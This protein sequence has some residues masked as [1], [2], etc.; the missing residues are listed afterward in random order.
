MASI[1]PQDFF[2]KKRDTSEIKSEILNR[3]FNTWCGIILY[4]QKKRVVNSVL[5]ID[6]YSGPGY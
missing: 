3:Y 4:G 2:K 5:Y 1:E 6:L